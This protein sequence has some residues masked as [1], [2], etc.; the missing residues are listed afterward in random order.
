MAF[1]ENIPGVGT[2]EGPAWT[3][4]DNNS[5]RVVW[6]GSGTDTTIWTTSAPTLQPNS[7]G[8]YGFAGQSQLK[9]SGRNIW[10]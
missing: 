2:T 10:D 3:V 7:A 8:V 9:T 4:H 5:V 1:Q 6:K